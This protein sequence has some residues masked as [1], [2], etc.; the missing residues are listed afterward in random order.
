VGILLVLT[1]RSIVEALRWVAG[2]LVMLQ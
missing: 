2:N 1:V